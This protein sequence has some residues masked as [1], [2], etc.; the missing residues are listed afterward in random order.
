MTYWRMSRQVNIEG[1]REGTEPTPGIDR[2]QA[3]RQMRTAREILKRLQAKPGQILADEVGMGKTYTALA[4]AASVAM[5]NPKAG[6]VVIM[7]PPALRDKWPLDWE[8]FKELY[9]QGRPPS[10]A[11]ADR[12]GQFL[13]LIDDP[14]PDRP[15]IVF[16]KNGAFGAQLQDPWIKLAVIRQALL[17]RRS[18]DHE[19]RAVERWGCRV[20]R[21]GDLDRYEPNLVRA[22]LRTPYG[23]WRRVARAFGHDI[24]DPIPDALRPTIDRINLDPVRQALAKLPLKASKHADAKIRAASFEIDGAI[25]GLWREWLNQADFRAPLLVLDEAHHAKNP[26][27]QLSRLF[28]NEEEGGGENPGALYSRFERM[29]FLTATPFQLGH[30]ELL[31]VLSRFSGVNWKTLPGSCEE[32][33]AQI[34]R[35]EEQ[36]TGAQRAMATLDTV[37]GRL[38]ERDLPEPDSTDW[39]HPSS[40]EPVSERAARVREEM[41]RAL[42]ARDEAQRDLKAW[43]IRH[44]KGDIY[45]SGTPRRRIYRGAEITEGRSNGGGLDINSGTLLPFLLAARAQVAFRAAQRSGELAGRARALFADGICSSYEA[46]LDTRRGRSLDDDVNPD[47]VT[48]EEAVTWYLDAI[49]K[50][51]PRDNPS[52]RAAHPKISP[53]VERVRQ[54]WL[55]GEKVVVFCHFRA[56]G[57][58]LRRHI[59]RAIEHDLTENVVKEYGVPAGEARVTLRRLAARLERRA[60]GQSPVRTAAEKALRP[61]LSGLTSDAAEYADELQ[62]IL[63]RYLRSP[64]VLARYGA[65]VFHDGPKGVRSMLNRKGLGGAPLRERFRSFI[66]YINGLVRERREQ[67]IDALDAVQRAGYYAAA[68]ELA[69]EGAGERERL[70]PTVRLAN[71]EV[72]RV[73]RRRLMLAFN[74]PLLPEVLVASQV[75]SEGVDLH[76]DCRYVIHHDLDWNPSTLEQRTGRIDRLKSKSERLDAPIEIYLPYLAETQDEKMYRVVRDRERWFQVV[77]GGRHELD[78]AEIDALSERVP[79]PADA[80]MALSFELQLKA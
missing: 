23:R 36:L 79:L 69:E 61:I 37:W 1:H 24:D 43:V 48:D 4:V 44:S 35:L 65:P 50:A 62:D 51:L 21:R 49:N 57:S 59:S 68:G 10:S 75:L 58:A 5:E 13:K 54:L 52:S 55:A 27:A 63:L 46:Y 6:P 18:L 15:Q 64:V 11:Q 31:Q 78:E 56:T 66:H 19:R 76:Q 33:E 38:R 45:P 3:R 41:G 71:G 70:I 34:H 17:R 25:K 77:M 42:R 72:D 28:L 80:A 16:L 26:G 53:T 32:F 14:Y 73:T 74:S 47:L 39:W 7:V 9:I 60:T 2:G 22:L 8:E 12:A 30:H 40:K 29:L 20:I 67:L